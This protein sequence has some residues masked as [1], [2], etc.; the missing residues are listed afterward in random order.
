MYALRS[1]KLVS[2]KGFKQLFGSAHATQP[3]VNREKR[4][5]REKLMNSRFISMAEYNRL[6]LLGI[7]FVV[8]AA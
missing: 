1:Y 3:I 7:L 5:M 4:A 8:G 6:D 2:S